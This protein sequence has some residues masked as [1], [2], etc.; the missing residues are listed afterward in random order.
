MKLIEI[1]DKVKAL[2]IPQAIFSDLT[3]V[4]V[5]TVDEDSPEP[6]QMFADEM[7][8]AKPT[9][10]I[11]KVPLGDESKHYLLHTALP[12]LIDIAMDNMNKRHVKLLQRFQARLHAKMT[13]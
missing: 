8:Q 2:L 11:W 3:A 6:K 13:G 4:E 10:N 7:R 1:K 12:N 9:T 5:D